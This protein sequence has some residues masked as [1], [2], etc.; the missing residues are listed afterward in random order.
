MTG[1]QLEFKVIQ[2]PGGERQLLFI[3]GF[4]GNFEQPG[5]EWYMNRIR[6]HDYDATYVQLP[7]RV[8]D[9]M[10][11]VIKPCM[12]VEK[13]LD[14]HVAVGFSF[15]GLTLTYMF[16]ARRRIFVSP[17]LG[18]NEKWLAKGHKTVVRLLSLISR[19]ILKRQFEKE[20]AGPLAVNDDMKGLPEFVSFRTIDQLFRMQD[21]VPEPRQD[22]VVF[23]SPEDK[24][25]SVARIEDRIYENEL[26]SHTYRGGH[27]FY[28]TRDRKEMVSS[29][30]G[31]IG[32]G[33]S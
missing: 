1:E 5:V 24:V 25:V 32:D 4:G 8:D 33:F 6:E 11:D 14:E 19:P 13:G 15:G 10:E 17:F 2:V 18:V 3:N 20:D 30:L 12:E 27:M 22:D 9:Y 29:L 7:T 26:R 28:L 23:Y 31:E 21:S 16:G